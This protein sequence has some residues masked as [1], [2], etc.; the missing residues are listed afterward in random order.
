MK[1]VILL[2]ALLIVP[3]GFASKYVDSATLRDCGGRVE[4]RESRD[5]LHLQFE[6]VRHCHDLTIKNSRG[7]VLKQ[8]SFKKGGND[9]PYSP[10]YTLSNQM[11]RELDRGRLVLVVSGWGNRDEVSLRVNRWGDGDLGGHDP[12]Q[13]G[14]HEKARYTGF[15][16]T[17]SCKCAYYRNGRFIR[18]AT[19]IE[20][21]YKCPKR[22]R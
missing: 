17:N 3:Q 13:C 21:R 11:W 5:N 9:A 22:S 18:H 19:P 4:L 6:R 16:L 2:L 12:G 10:S 15:A 1:K 20:Q 14:G 8:Y 7:R